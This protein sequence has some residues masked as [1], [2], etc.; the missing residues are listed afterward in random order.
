MDFSSFPLD[1]Q[2]CSLELESC[3]YD[4]AAG[5]RFCV[6]LWSCSST[7]HAQK[8][9][10]HNVLA[11]THTAQFGLSFRRRDEVTSPSYEQI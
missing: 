2:N 8:S 1:T 5:G 6:E 7:E 11:G 3:E 9:T 4:T 10:L